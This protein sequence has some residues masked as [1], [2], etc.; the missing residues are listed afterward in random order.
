MVF[1]VSQVSSIFSSSCR[2]LI[3]FNAVSVHLWATRH[4]IP[5]FIMSFFIVTVSII[6]RSTRT[7]SIIF[8]QHIYYVVEK[9]HNPQSL[10][11]ELFVHLLFS[12]WHGWPGTTV[13][14]FVTAFASFDVDATTHS[15]HMHKILRLPFVPLPPMHRS[16]LHPLLGRGRP[17]RQHRYRVESVGHFC[18]PAHAIHP[19]E[20][21]RIA[22]TW[23]IKAV[24]GVFRR[25]SIHLEDEESAH[26]RR[27]QVA[28]W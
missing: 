14:I 27:C 5:A 18:L 2:S 4:Y 24:I 22:L 26:S 13:L 15:P 6:L 8:L 7:R 16:G 17:S 25:G 9:F 20:C 12:L 10:P 11:D 1:S 3:I 21:V 28:N 19:L 23:V